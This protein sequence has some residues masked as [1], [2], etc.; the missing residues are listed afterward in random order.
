MNETPLI[1]RSLA[2]TI[3]KIKW[4]F[5][6][7]EFLTLLFAVLLA[8]IFS[9]F[10]CQQIQHLK[11]RLFG[12]TPRIAFPSKRGARRMKNAV[13]ESNEVLNEEMERESDK[14]VDF[15]KRVKRKMD[16]DEQG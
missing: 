5:D 11:Y 13:P 10:I 14:M 8:N 4:L 9:F 16:D 3:L 15:L 1:I 12:G 6:N 2:E 7:S